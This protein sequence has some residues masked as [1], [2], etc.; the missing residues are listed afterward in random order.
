MTRKYFSMYIMSRL[1]ESL[2]DQIIANFPSENELMN[3][4]L[5]ILR[6]GEAQYEVRNVNS[7]DFFDI[8][9]IPLIVGIK[10]WQRKKE[11]N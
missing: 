2:L 9:E 3:P 1:P 10:T 11:Q 8:Q 4:Y 6:T 7:V 5:I